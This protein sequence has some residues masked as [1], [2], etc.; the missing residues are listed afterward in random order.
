MV[1]MPL[2]SIQSLNL[3]FCLLPD[4]DLMSGGCMKKPWS[5]FGHY[6]LSGM[7]GIRA[8]YAVLNFSTE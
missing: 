7:A 1:L 8:S 3:S 5:D 4:V 2:V 6:A